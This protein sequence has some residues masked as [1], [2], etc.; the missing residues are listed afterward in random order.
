MKINFFV[1]FVGRIHVL[2][3]QTTSNCSNW[4]NWPWNI[5]W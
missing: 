2:L 5:C 4:L 3:I 1:M